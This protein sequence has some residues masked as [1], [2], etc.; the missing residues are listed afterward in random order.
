[1]GRGDG[2]GGS[3]YGKSLMGKGERSDGYR[4]D[5]L[6]WALARRA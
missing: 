3:E 5:I 2:R 1:M 4:G 6:L